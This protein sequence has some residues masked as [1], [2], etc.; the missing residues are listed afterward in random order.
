MF[1]NQPIFSSERNRQNQA[2]YSAALR[3]E[4]RSPVA[5][6]GGPERQREKFREYAAVQ[7]ISI[8]HSSAFPPGLDHSGLAHF[9]QPSCKFIVILKTFSGAVNVTKGHVLVHQAD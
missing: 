8:H 3:R 6:A 7:N 4:G 2:S 1:I 5:A 9:T